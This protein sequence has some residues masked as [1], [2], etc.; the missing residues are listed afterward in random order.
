MNRLITDWGGKKVREQ[1]IKRSTKKLQKST[2]S[3]RTKKRI[4]KKKKA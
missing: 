3:R 1:V 2:A 4:Q